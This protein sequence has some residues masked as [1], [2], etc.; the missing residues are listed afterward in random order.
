M[1]GSGP[2]GGGSDWLR[3]AMASQ[4]ANIN[5]ANTWGQNQLSQVYAPA[6]EQVVNPLQYAPGQWTNYM[7]GQNGQGGLQ[8]NVA[9][10]PGQIQ[11]LGQGFLAPQG[12]NNQAMQNWVDLGNGLLQGGAQQLGQQISAN[13]GQ[14]QV[15]NQ[16][17]M[18]ALDTL[19]PMVQQAG[20]VFGSG[21]WTP[22]YQQGFGSISD[23]LGG[24][25]VAPGLQGVQSTANNIL[26]NQGMTPTL[27][28]AQNPL[29][30]ILGRQGNNAQSQALLGGALPF[31]Q[32]GGQTNLSQGLANQGMNLFN[33]QALMNPAQAAGLAGNLAHTAA[34]GQAQQAEANALARGGGPGAVVANGMTNQAMSDF[35]NQISQQTS[36]AESTA[37]QNQ[38]QLQLQQQ[39]GGAQAAQGAGSL[40][41]ALLGTSGGL[42][43]GSGNL[44]NSL[45]MGGLN[46]LPSLQNAQTNF[47]GAGS[48]LAQL[49]N[50]GFLGGINAMTPMMSAQNQYALGMGNLVN[51][52]GQWQTGDQNNAMANMAS[53]LNNTMGAGVNTGQLGLGSGALGTNQFNALTGAMNQGLNTGINMGNMY[54]N[55]TQAYLNPMQYLAGQY[56]NLWNTSLNSGSSL[57]GGGAGTAGGTGPDLGLLTSA[58]GALGGM[59][60]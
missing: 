3:G 4:F 22:Q 15:L 16:A 19:N 50:T 37:L 53:L 14:E 2:L 13:Q 44:A 21:G 57:F 36:G 43:Q 23:L 54:N 27:A 59:I 35:A 51:N 1:S 8:S 48:N 32:T 31:L 49:A 56:G 28:M 9:Q 58:L 5:N 10:Y 52:A 45:F 40:Q 18:N 34:Q 42:A 20:Q 30:G 17:Q 41:N 24:G 39:L 26:A 29:E 6:I 60:P 11:Q 46:E 38:Q 7:W 25:G 47:L 33:Q 12:F 55:M